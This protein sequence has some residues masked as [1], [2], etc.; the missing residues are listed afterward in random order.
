LDF[1]L[2][3]LFEEKNASKIMRPL[4]REEVATGPLAGAG[5]LGRILG[6][7]YNELGIFERKR[8]EVALQLITVSCRWLYRC[9]STL[10]R[11]MRKCSGMFV[12]FIEWVSSAQCQWGFPGNLN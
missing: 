6:S 5:Y 4:R 11:R 8:L 3:L 10:N 7:K 12:N 9:F 2:F 1:Y